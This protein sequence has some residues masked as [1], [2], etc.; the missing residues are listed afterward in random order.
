M[1]DYTTEV[2][3]WLPKGCEVLSRPEPFVVTLPGGGTYEL[4]LKDERRP[5]TGQQRLTYTV[6]LNAT[7]AILDNWLFSACL[8]LDR[9]LM[10]P[11]MSTIVVR[12][13]E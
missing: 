2:D 8:E 3:I 11:E 7:P 5:Y 10:A 12:L 6:R 13:P 4:A 9:R 1:N